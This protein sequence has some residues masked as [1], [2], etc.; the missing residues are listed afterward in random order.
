MPERNNPYL[1]WIVYCLIWGIEIGLSVSLPAGRTPAKE[2][3]V[4]SS[5]MYKYSNSPL[6][7][8]AGERIGTSP[9]KGA[10][11]IVGDV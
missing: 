4:S 2:A 11:L 3:S 10:S 1:F 5:G 7:G 6:K 8:C 9:L